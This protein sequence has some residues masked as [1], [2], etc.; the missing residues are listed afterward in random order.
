[1]Q[2]SVSESCWYSNSLIR[3]QI[4]ERR[5]VFLRDWPARLRKVCFSP[6]EVFGLTPFVIGSHLIVRDLVSSLGVSVSNS[7][8]LPVAFYEVL[9]LTFAQLR[10]SDSLTVNIC[11]AP[12][13]AAAR[14]YYGAGS[15][16]SML[17]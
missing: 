15:F 12:P 13:L 4:S 10:V 5:K 7:L 3:Y 8:R 14:D 2:Q 11:R 17:P 1:M 9:S 16:V 6:H